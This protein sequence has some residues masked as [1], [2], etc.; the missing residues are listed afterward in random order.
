LDRRL[1]PLI[2]DIGGGDVPL[3]SGHSF[4]NFQADG[5]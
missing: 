4:D 3:Y 1:L 5:F 2:A